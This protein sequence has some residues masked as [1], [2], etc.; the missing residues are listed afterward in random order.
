[1]IY[2]IFNNIFAVLLKIPNIN[3]RDIL[4]IITSI[5]L[6]HYNYEHNRMVSFGAML[7][8]LMYIIMLSKNLAIITQSITMIMGLSRETSI[9]VVVTVWTI[10]LVLLMRLSFYRKF[11]KHLVQLV[12]PVVFLTI[13]FVFIVLYNIIG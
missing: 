1:M 5:Y 7:V 13:L 6:Y 10:I 3:A 2:E 9:L 8:M 11:G 12:P 4:L